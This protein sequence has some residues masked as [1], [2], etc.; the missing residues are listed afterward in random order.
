MGTRQRSGNGTSSVSSAGSVAMVGSELRRLRLAAGLTQEQIATRMG[1]QQAAVSKIEKGGDV[2]LS[3]IQRYVEAL[4]AW[5]RMNAHFASDAPLS[6]S[7]CEA[8]DVEPGDDAQL[9]L[10][11]FGDEP[12]KPRRDVVL[13]IKPVYSERILAGEKTV[14]LRRR[15]PATAPNGALAYIYSTSPVKAIVG[16]ASIQDVLKLPVEQIWTEFESTAFIERSH[17]DKYFDGV[18]HGFAL[19]FDDVRAF[20]R[21]LPLNEL[22]EKFGFEPPQSFLYAKHELRKALKDEP[23]VVS[24]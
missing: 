23:A 5:L 17:F 14:E 8:F 9:V 7:L 18:D 21:P 12:L 6:L 11:L 1:V 16:T 4:G 2:H 24:H 3:T 20:T 22:R 15:F 10:P 13:S 19:V